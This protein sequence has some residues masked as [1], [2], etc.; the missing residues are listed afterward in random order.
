MGCWAKGRGTTKLSHY[1][2]PSFYLDSHMTGSLKSGALPRGTSRELLQA[3]LDSG[4]EPCSSSR[5]SSL[6]THCCLIMFRD[7]SQRRY[8]MW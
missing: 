6:A 5:C 2:G 4:S 7:E 8:T 1:F 3:A